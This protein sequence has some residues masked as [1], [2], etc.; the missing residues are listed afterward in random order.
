MQLLVVL[1]FLIGAC[2]A[3]APSSVPTSTEG[4]ALS[5]SEVPSTQSTAK[6]P[7]I[8]C[9]GNVVRLNGIAH[10]PAG[11]ATLERDPAS[12]GILVTVGP[13]GADG[14][15]ARYKAGRGMRRTFAYPSRPGALSWLVGGN[16]NRLFGASFT[17]VNG[18]NYRI[19]IDFTG[20]G[21][22][23]ATAEVYD[24]GIRVASGPVAPR[25]PVARTRALMAEEVA[26]EIVSR[27]EYAIVSFS[28]DVSTEITLN[29]LNGPVSA[30]GDEIRLVGDRADSSPIRVKGDVWQFTV[31]TGAERME[32]VARSIEVLDG[33]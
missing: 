18:S 5:G 25:G 6:A 8:R 24:Q 28:R 7:A 20:A 1:L 17:D 27:A 32:V 16:R 10:R 31:N 26:F 3:I 33:R 9:R 23:D 21:V 11:E 14:F 19:V 12:G 13:S 2:D 22:V 29:T 4:I 30:R 15:C